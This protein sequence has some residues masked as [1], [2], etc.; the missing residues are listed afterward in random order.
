[1]TDDEIKAGREEMRKTGVCPSCRMRGFKSLF[2][3]G[4]FVSAP[5]QVGC[6]LR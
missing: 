5:H 1:M 6:P 3:V 4:E 2:F